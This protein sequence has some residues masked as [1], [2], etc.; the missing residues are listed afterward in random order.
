MIWC[1]DVCVVL[2]LKG[3][4]VFLSN[5]KIYL[6]IIICEHEYLIRKKSSGVKCVAVAPVQTKNYSV[7]T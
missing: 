3:I 7:N 6:F 2:C 4:N 5:T 1:L